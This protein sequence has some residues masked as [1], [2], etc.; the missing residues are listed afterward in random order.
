MGGGRRRGEGRGRNKKGGKRRGPPKVGSHSDVPNPEK[1]PDRRTAL[2]GGGQHRRLPRA[3][4]TLAP[5][6][7]ILVPFAV[8]QSFC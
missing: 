6:L 8:C 2:I 1:N 3:E 5:P 4:N 7:F